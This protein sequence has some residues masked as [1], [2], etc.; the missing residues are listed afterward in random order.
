MAPRCVLLVCVVV[1]TLHCA[2]SERD[3]QL[4]RRWQAQEGSYLNGRLCRNPGR[5]C[6]RRGSGCFS[7][8]LR[9]ACLHSCLWSRNSNP[10][11]LLHRRS[12]LA[13]SALSVPPGLQPREGPQIEVAPSRQ[14]TPATLA[15]SAR[16]PFLGRVMFLHRATLGGVIGCVYTPR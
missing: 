8:A 16:P 6:V 2:R 15:D 10:A 1:C 3:R 7:S 9:D 12:V 11:M 14:N 4:N 13:G 5:F